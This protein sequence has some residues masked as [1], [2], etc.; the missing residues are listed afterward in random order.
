MA[1]VIVTAYLL[2][3]ALVLILMCFIGAKKSGADKEEI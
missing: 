2:C 1:F 3:I